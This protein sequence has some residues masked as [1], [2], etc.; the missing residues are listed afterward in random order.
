[1]AILVVEHDMEFVMG[2]CDEVIV[3]DFGR[4]IASGSPEEVRIDPEVIAAYLGVEL[5]E[6]D[7]EIE[8]EPES[9]SAPVAG[10]GS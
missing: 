2:V 4:K 1:M 3:L 5:D 7:H 6:R 8:L 10:G 9:A